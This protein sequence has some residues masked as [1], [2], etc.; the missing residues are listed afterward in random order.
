MR[1]GFWVGPAGQVVFVEGGRYRRILIWT[2]DCFGRYWH[3]EEIKFF[4]NGWEY[5]GK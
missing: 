5:V 3:H 2:K 1:N 4:L